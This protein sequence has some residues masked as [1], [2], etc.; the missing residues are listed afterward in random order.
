[1]EE[2]KSVTPEIMN[3][4]TGTSAKPVFVNRIPG[5]R[6]IGTVVLTKIGTQFYT[7]RNK[8]VHKKWY[9]VICLKPGCKWMGRILK[10]PE[11]T[12]LETPKAQDHTCTSI[13]PCRTEGSGEYF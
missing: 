4:S 11:N 6:G 9:T 13:D 1:M 3:N 12:F 8:N 5:K 10:D 7:A 2:V